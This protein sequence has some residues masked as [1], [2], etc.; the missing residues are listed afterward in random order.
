[1]DATLGSLGE[2]SALAA[3]YERALEKKKA[4][5]RWE[6]PDGLDAERPENDCAEP[7][8]RD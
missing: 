4:V 6:S 3:I 2:L 1:M 8:I 5:G 7:S